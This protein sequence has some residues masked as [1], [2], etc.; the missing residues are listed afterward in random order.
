MFKTREQDQI[1]IIRIS[2]IRQ[3]SF[4]EYCFF[5]SIREMAHSLF[6]VFCICGL[7]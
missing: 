6:Y 2:F 7:H 4:V 1:G 3:W 5:C